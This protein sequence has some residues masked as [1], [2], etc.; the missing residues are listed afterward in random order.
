VI[1]LVGQN[2]AGRLPQCQVRRSWLHVSLLVTVQGRSG[3]LG[4]AGEYHSVTALG[5]H[6]KLNVIALD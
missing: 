3:P 5:K 6:L 1:H 2:G 4:E